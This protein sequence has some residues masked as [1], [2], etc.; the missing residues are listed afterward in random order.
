LNVQQGRLVKTQIGGPNL[1]V[2]GSVNQEWGLKICMSNEKL[3]LLTCNTVRNSD[4][5]KCM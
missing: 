5:E 2:F 1:K 4:L 3:V